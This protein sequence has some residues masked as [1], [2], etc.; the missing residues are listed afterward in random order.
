MKI[1][2]APLNQGEYLVEILPYL[3]KWYK[4]YDYLLFDDFYPTDVEAYT[5]AIVEDLLDLGPYA[6]VIE[7][8]EEPAGFLYLNEWYGS[9]TKHHSCQIHAVIDKKFHRQGVGT[10]VG[11]LIL[12][13]LFE[14]LNLFRVEGWLDPEN[15][16]MIH[17]AKKMGFKFEGNARGRKLVNGKPRNE[18]MFGLIRPDYFRRKKPLL[19]SSNEPQKEKQRESS[20][21]PATAAS[22]GQ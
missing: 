14:Q 12:S 13:L 5:Q 20:N 10:A 8:A 4:D 6:W 3:L 1:E 19:R 16:A 9:G 15:K 18:L 22:T 2:L 11:D 21:C 17:L 7:V